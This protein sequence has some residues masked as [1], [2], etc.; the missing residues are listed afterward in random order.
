MVCFPFF[1]V[2][3]KGPPPIP[4]KRIRPPG[5]GRP[6]LTPLHPQNNDE[7]N[8]MDP[9]NLLRGAGEEVEEEKVGPTSSDGDD[10]EAAEVSRAEATASE[11]TPEES[12]EP[13]REPSPA[14]PSPVKPPTPLPPRDRTD[15]K[16][17]LEPL[18]F[19]LL[20]RVKKALRKIQQLHCPACI[21]FETHESRLEDIC[22][23]LRLAHNNHLLRGLGED[24][25]NR[26]FAEVS[27]IY[28]EDVSNE[29]ADEYEQATGDSLLGRRPL[30]RFCVEPLDKT[31]SCDL[32]NV[33][34]LS[35]KEMVQ[36]LRGAHGFR[37]YPC[38]ECG[39][40]FKTYGYF[41]SHLV[42]TG[43]ESIYGCRLCGIVGMV[44]LYMLQSHLRTHSL[45]D[46]C[47]TCFESQTALRKH[48]FNHQQD[49]PYACTVCQVCS[50]LEN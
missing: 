17:L 28:M 25:Q 35:V 41:I 21:R 2:G 8:V 42:S 11:Q 10:S 1:V 36:H 33:N 23:H 43:K 29:E 7:N 34:D 14:P 40:Q 38:L 4:P 37:M 5:L 44:S 47:H 48:M 49:S 22:S 20:L 39:Q 24:T 30:H 46:I 26:L 9:K 32:C 15:W 31:Y 6:T 16:S 45:C 12:V 27:S 18:L 3:S 19:K 13:T 50:S